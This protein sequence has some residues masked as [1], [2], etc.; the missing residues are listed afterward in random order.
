MMSAL[1]VDRFVVQSSRK[2]GNMSEEC[3]LTHDLRGQLGRDAD[4]DQVG[5]GRSD[6]LR[7]ALQLRGDAVEVPPGGT[8]QLLVRVRLQLHLV[9]LPPPVPTHKDGKS[10]RRHAEIFLGS[11]GEISKATVE[12]QTAPGPVGV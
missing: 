6:G 5:Q 10:A 11:F 4:S 3:T 12:T 9:H 8:A 7:G 1:D 2:S